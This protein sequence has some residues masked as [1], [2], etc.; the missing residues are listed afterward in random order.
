[1]AAQ[2]A[3]K[4]FMAFV[5]G[6]MACM[7]LFVGLPRKSLKQA[8]PFFPLDEREAGETIFTYGGPG[9]AVFILMHGSVVITDRHNEVISTLVAEQVCKVSFTEH[10]SDFLC[11]P[12]TPL[13]CLWDGS[14]AGPARERELRAL[15]Q[16]P[17]HPCTL[18]VNTLRHQ[19]HA[20]PIPYSGIDDR[21]AP[22]CLSPQGQSASSARAADAEVALGLPIFGEDAF[23]DRTKPRLSTARTVTACKLLVLRIEQFSNIQLVVSD[24]KLRMRRLKE[25]QRVQEERDDLARAILR[26]NAS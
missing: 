3:R 23:M 22:R 4:V 15:A 11:L 18:T 24:L 2:V 25:A 6:E 19:T 17:T 20:I 10:Y 5:E 12:Y 9:N 1:M 7:S 14:P 8:V 16:P 13:V 26:P 21:T